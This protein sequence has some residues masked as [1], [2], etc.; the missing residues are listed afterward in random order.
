MIVIDNYFLL[1]KFHLFCVLQNNNCNIQAVNTNSKRQ[2]HICIS[3]HPKLALLVVV[4]GAT[5]VISRTRIRNRNNGVKQKLSNAQSS[6][7][8]IPQQQQDVVPADTEPSTSGN[9]SII[10]KTSATTSVITCLLVLTAREHHALITH[11]LRAL[12]P[13]LPAL[14]HAKL[15]KLDNLLIGCLLLVAT[16]MLAVMVAQQVCW[17]GT[18]L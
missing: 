13:N 7:H 16:T 9:S 1:E 6:S 14:S 5:F 3:M 4:G 2:T 15:C 11:Q 8:A 17:E 18:H 10:I 12:L